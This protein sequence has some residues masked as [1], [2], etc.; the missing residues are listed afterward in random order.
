MSLS[1]RLPRSH[2]FWPAT[3]IFSATC[4][5]RPLTSIFLLPLGS[6]LSLA[7]LLPLGPSD[8]PSPSSSHAP[9]QLPVPLHFRCFTGP[10]IQNGSQQV[11][12]SSS[13][14]LCSSSTPSAPLPHANAFPNPHSLYFRPA[15]KEAL[16]N[17][18][19]PPRLP[20]FFSAY[21]FLSCLCRCVQ[22][23]HWEP[24]Q[25]PNAIKNYPIKSSFHRSL[26]T[27]A[28]NANQSISD[29]LQAILCCCND[30][31]DYVRLYVN[32]TLLPQESTSICFQYLLNPLI[33]YSLWY[34]IKIFPI[35]CIRTTR[36]Q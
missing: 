25:P 31:P 5:T 26:F 23:E 2:I 6:R 33:T 8:L 29:H 10:R 12:K 1:H 32:I 14:L 19:H 20:R 35:R 21:L 16:P 24:A 7:N 30:N 18:S 3:L 36:V 9:Q 15:S 27:Q 28:L 4:C 11:H 17:C 13:T 22:E 34:I